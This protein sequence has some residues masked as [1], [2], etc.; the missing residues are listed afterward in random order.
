VGQRRQWLEITINAVAARGH[1]DSPNR[2]LDLETSSLAPRPGCGG[3]AICVAASKHGRF[4]D[5]KK[6]V[7]ERS[8]LFFFP[9]T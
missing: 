3:G 7:F 1:P 5:Q 9:K 8:E 2:R 6:N 4:W